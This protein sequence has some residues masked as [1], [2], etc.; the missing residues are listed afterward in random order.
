MTP[1]TDA[2][3]NYWKKCISARKDKD[4][5]GCGF[6]LEA[7]LIVARLEAAE[8]CIIPQELIGSLEEKYEAWRKSCGEK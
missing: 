6:Y 1:F 2:K 3:L 8:A 4:L 7:P 5:K